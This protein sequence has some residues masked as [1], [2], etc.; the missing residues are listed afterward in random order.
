MLKIARVVKETAEEV[1]LLGIGIWSRTQSV[2]DR[3]CVVDEI[4]ICK[5]SCARIRVHLCGM[6][7]GPLLKMP[8]ATRF[9]CNAVD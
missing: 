3:L 8:L 1:V 9:K 7:I 5:E 6:I 2:L 4:V